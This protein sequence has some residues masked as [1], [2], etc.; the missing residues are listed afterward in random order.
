MKIL[1]PAKTKIFLNSNMILSYS[2]K[3]WNWY[4]EQNQMTTFSILLD[5]VYQTENAL[6]SPN[7]KV[8]CEYK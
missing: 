4:P 7:I 1:R 8:I 3:N 5:L 6:G 2:E